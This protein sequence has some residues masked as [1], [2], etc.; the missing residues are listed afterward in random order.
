MVLRHLSHK[1]HYYYFDTGNM[2]FF[3]Y[4]FHSQFL[5]TLESRFHRHFAILLHSRASL[6]RQLPVVLAGRCNCVLYRVTN[7]STYVIK[8]Y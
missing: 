7:L 2:I 5:P 4:F 6:K 1:I 8:E 3:C